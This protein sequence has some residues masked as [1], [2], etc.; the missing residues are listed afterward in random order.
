MEKIM[1]LKIN[2]FGDVVKKGL[3]LVTAGESI[4]KIL[5]NH[6]KGM[7]RNKKLKLVQIGGPLGICLREAQ[8]DTTLA[9]YTDEM[10]ANTIL[11]LDD[12]MCPVDF[13]RFLTRYVTR[14]LRISND[15]IKEINKI[16]ENISKGQANVIDGERL[17][18]LVSEK[19][20]AYPEKPLFELLRYMLK[21]FKT[22]IMEHIEKKRCR[23][24]IC[25]RLFKA[26]CVNACPAGMNIPCFNALMLEGK[27]EEAY[28]LMR[29]TIPFS[30]VC[31]NLCDRPC[32]SA[33][34][35]GQIEGTT[36]VRVLQAYAA[37]MSQKVGDY[38]ENISQSNGK[39][40]AI[41]GAGLAG[42]SAAYFLGKTGYDV[43]LY[44]MNNFV[45]GKLLCEISEDILPKALIEQE[46]QY[47]RNIGI[48]I[49]I[50]KQI[51]IDISLDKLRETFDVILVA[52]GSPMDETRKVNPITF[53]TNVKGVFAVGDVSEQKS[54]IETLAEAKNT[55]EAIDR[56]LGGGGLY[57]GEEIDIPE[58]QLDCRIW[59]IPKPKGIRMRNFTEDEV[60]NE[61]SRCLR[62]DRNS[63]Q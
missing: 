59:D 38:K 37:N 24:G 3:E 10:H 30:F 22:E 44:E 28:S 19:F 56:Y 60:R 42:L 13:M 21:E 45:G 61:A 36:G 43:I 33:C 26:Q 16:I 39:K 46:M 18:K 23:T 35:R 17:E 58:P 48:E 1:E 20:D 8:I 62:C 49:V 6:A 40:I 50:N 7:A 9:Q 51:G 15:S 31:A 2:V 52:T 47:L 29:Q 54:A 41:V 27:T 32:E 63:N 55:A 57:I 25:H 34:R 53:S 14:E 11:F 12:S 5:I 4:R